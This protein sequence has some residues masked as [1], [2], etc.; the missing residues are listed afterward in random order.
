MAFTILWDSIEPGVQNVCFLS[1]LRLCT[2]KC[3]PYIKIKVSRDFKSGKKVQDWT[4]QVL[5]A[6][7]QGTKDILIAQTETNKV[8]QTPPTHWKETGEG[9]RS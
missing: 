5:V 8:Q 1:F 2:L 3:L 4:A 6:E 7:N 9:G